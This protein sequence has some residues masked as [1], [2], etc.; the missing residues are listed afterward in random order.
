VARSPLTEAGVEA[1]TPVLPN[2]TVVARRGYDAIAAFSPSASDSEGL[3]RRSVLQV[4]RL[5]AR[6]PARRYAVS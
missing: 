3:N 6:L 2:G 1:T 4:E 5:A